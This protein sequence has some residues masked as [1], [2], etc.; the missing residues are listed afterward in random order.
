ME[1]EADP[2][3]VAVLKAKYGERKYQ[4]RKHQLRSKEKQKKRV[5]TDLVL[6][7]QRTGQVFSRQVS[8]IFL[9]A[10]P[11]NMIQICELIIY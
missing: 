9:L 7:G 1:K 6:L 10:G 2:A 8:A 4:T 3:G 5:A 11:V